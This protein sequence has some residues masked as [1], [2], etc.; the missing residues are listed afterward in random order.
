MLV[1][2]AEI[3]GITVSRK[4]ELYPVD[5]SLVA[6]ARDFMS[7]GAFASSSKTKHSVKGG[8]AGKRQTL[9]KAKKRL[10]KRR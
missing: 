10:C 4:N 2:C 6:Y 9:L 8:I 7:S 5:Q 1:T 3:Q